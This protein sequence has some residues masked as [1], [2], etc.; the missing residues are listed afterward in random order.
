MTLTLN[1]ENQK[2]RFS[3]SDYIR[4]MHVLRDETSIS[5]LK[6]HAP[7]SV[8]IKNLAMYNYQ[9]AKSS[10]F[11]SGCS[12]ICPELFLDTMYIGLITRRSIMQFTFKKEGVLKYFVSWLREHTGLN[13]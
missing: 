12:H 13:L 1:F 9:S 3:Q 8:L 5:V 6:T 4:V 2:S 10:E 11:M 7:D